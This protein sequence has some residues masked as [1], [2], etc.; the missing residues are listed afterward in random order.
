MTFNPFYL[1]A[2]FC[3]CLAAASQTLLKKSALKE[4]RGRFGDYLNPCVITGYLLLGICLLLSLINY[5]RLGYLRAV[6]LEPIGYILVLIIGRFVFGERLTPK[7]LL[8]MACILAGI[9][10]FHLT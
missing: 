8:G 9:C 10:F 5:R 1:L 6:T 7:R 4:H 3:Q 2:L